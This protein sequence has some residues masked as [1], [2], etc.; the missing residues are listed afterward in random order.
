MGAFKASQGGLRR[1]L[2]EA[3][4]ANWG[5]EKG[6]AKLASIELK[7]YKLFKKIKQRFMGQGVW[8]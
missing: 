6:E 8:N 3:R 7:T 2:Q 1:T 4:Q 5:G